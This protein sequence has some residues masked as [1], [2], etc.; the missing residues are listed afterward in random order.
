MTDPVDRTPPTLSVGVAMIA[1]VVAAGV[2]GLFAGEGLATGT[3]GVLLLG[4]GVVRSARRLVTLGAGAML[5][6][7]ILAGY[8]WV[9][10]WA[11]LVSVAATVVAWDVAENAIGLGEQVGRQAETTRAELAHAGGSTAV[12]VAT[13]V[14]AYGVFRVVSGGQ[15]ATALVL[16][17]AALVVLTAVLRV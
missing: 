1:G 15:P 7:A 11:V 2:P 16:T 10:P 12:A 13:A 9:P 4:V 17:V 8:A 5:L 6:G 14:G 3:V